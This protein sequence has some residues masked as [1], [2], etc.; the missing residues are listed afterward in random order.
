MEK[1]KY[2]SNSSAMD[3]AVRTLRTNISF[4]SVDSKLKSLLITS[5]SPSE[6]KSTVTVNLGRSMAENGS[7]VLIIDCD[8]RHPSIGDVSGNTSM[9]G[10]T[11]YLVDKA[12]IN[13]I[14]IKDHKVDNLHLLLTG[15]KPPN[16]AEI[17][18]SKKMESLIKSLQDHYDMI[19]VD[20]PPVGIITDGAILSTFVGAVIMVVNQGETKAENFKLALKNLENVGA[21]ILG[22]VMNK[23]KM[24]SGKYGYGYGHYY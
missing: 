20:T 21:K 24:K 7:K 14:I 10:L 3:E 12:T 19:L 18:G 11:N 16:P 22:V 15:P 17:L 1:N 5:S 6:G 8:L 23:V 9:I 13:D 4:S 2:Y